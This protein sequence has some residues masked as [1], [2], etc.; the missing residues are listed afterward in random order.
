[1]CVCVP[2]DRDTLGSVPFRCSKYLRLMQPRAVADP[3]PGLRAQESTAM[4]LPLSAN[5]WSR[6]QSEIKSPIQTEIPAEGWLCARPNLFKEFT[7][8]ETWGGGGIFSF[9]YGVSLVK[10]PRSGDTQSSTSLSACFLGA[11]Q[12]NQGFAA[13]NIT[14]PLTCCCC[15]PIYCFLPQGIGRDLLSCKSV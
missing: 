15:C 5:I 3:S 10:P 12:T 13:W 14:H 8:I 9:R 4:P 1:M 7:I 6:Q 11:V 2:C